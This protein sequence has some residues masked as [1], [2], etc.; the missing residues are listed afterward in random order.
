M[1]K[2]C[3]QTSMEDKGKEA[4][5]ECLVNGDVCAGG[6]CEGEI[7]NDTTPLTKTEQEQTLDKV[8]GDLKF[9][10]FHVKMIVL[11]CGAYF[12]I[13]CQMLLIIFLSSP[14]KEEWKLDDFVFPVLPCSAGILGMAG[15]FTFGKLSDKYGRQKP[16][17]GAMTFVSIFGL[18]AAFSPKFW[19]LVAIRAFVAFGTS[20]IEAV[21]FV[22]LLGK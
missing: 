2:R 11:T 19:V 20:G 18:A 14:I 22:L 13:C 1:S 16:F 4:A 5:S 21:N 9:G 17:L 6:H 15:S 8:V 10:I 12:A 3:K 7:P